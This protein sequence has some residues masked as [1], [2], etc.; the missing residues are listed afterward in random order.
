MVSSFGLHQDAAVAR[1][2][3]QEG[4]RFFQFALGWHYGFGEQ[5][6]G[7]TSIW[8]LFQQA[9][10]TMAQQQA[11]TG[12]LAAAAAAEGG[13][14]TPDDLRNHLRKFDDCGVDQVAF[15]QQGGRNKHEHICEALEL[16][17][18]EVM[19]EFKEREAERVKRKA[20]H[21]APYVEAAFKRKQWMQPLADADIPKVVA[22]GR[23]VAEQAARTGQ[24]AP[25]GNPRRAAWAQA[26]AK[27]EDKS[28]TE[29]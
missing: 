24:P 6:P 2:R 23:Q 12:T 5:V 9:Q 16:F 18:G 25:A 7:R 27:S 26:L 14:G 8:D 15:I 1:E 22:L 3:F 4:F 20:E 11:E 13:I 28:K 10:A 21:L 17:A 29:A 19:G